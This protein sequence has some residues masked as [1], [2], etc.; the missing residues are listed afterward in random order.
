MCFITKALL[1]ELLKRVYMRLVWASCSNTCSVSLRYVHNH[2]TYTNNENCSSPSWQRQHEPRTF[3]VYLNDTGYRTGR[4]IHKHA[5]RL[6]GA[7]VNTSVRVL[8]LQPSL[9]ST[10]M[11]TTVRTFPPGGGNG[12]VWWRTA[13]STTTRCVAT[14]CERSTERSIHRWGH[15]AH[16]CHCTAK[17]AQ[18]SSYQSCSSLF[19]CGRQVWTQVIVKRLKQAMLI[20]LNSA[21]I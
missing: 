5:L 6:C 12:S 17:Q 4:Q 10:W 2:N 18:H 9:E 7:C 1:V 8:F 3:G 20:T 13:A 15:T 16:L 19:L 21:S 11:S 14:A